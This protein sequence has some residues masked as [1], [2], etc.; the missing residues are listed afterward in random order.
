M[1]FLSLASALLVS[2][3]SS[4]ISAQNPD[5]QSIY[6]ATCSACHGLEAQGNPATNSPRL[7]GQA[8]FY[9][10][11]QLRQFRDGRRGAHPDDANGALMRAMALGL[12]DE[13]IESLA[14]LLSTKGSEFIP[15]ELSGD[16]E[17]G[18]EIYQST[19]SSCHGISAEG[20]AHLQTPNLR[21][22]SYWYTRQQIATYRQGWRGEDTSG[23]IRATWMRGIA[24]HIE[25]DQI[26]DLS[27]YVQSLR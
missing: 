14:L 24:Q 12:D 3:F 6:N 26:Q 20:N 8:Q 18:R 15:E 4:V 19:C 27:I 23:N 7:A 22:L 2:L 25:E 1:R 9:L 13:Q 5:P 21:I 16:S 17:A 10:I 11:E